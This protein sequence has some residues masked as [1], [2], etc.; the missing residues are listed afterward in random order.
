MEQIISLKD[1]PSV[2]FSNELKDRIQYSKL[3]GYV[4]GRPTES[5]INSWIRQFKSIMQEYLMKQNVEFLH[6]T[7]KRCF[8]I[9]YLTNDIREKILKLK[10]AEIFGY[11]FTWKEEIVN[12]I[13]DL[14]PRTPFKC[15]KISN[16]INFNKKILYDFC[17]DTKYIQDNISNIQN[18]VYCK[19]IFNDMST[20]KVK[21]TEIRA[22]D[23]R[24]GIF[25]IIDNECSTKNLDHIFPSI[26]CI[27]TAKHIQES[28]GEKDR[29]NRAGSRESGEILTAQSRT[30]NGEISHKEEAVT[31]PGENGENN[32]IGLVS[33]PILGILV[34]S[35]LYKYTPLR[36]KFHSYFGNKEDIPV[37]QD[38]VTTEQMISD[39]SNIGDMYSE[40]EHYNLS[41]QTL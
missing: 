36:L 35:F 34:F 22:L 32:A 26:D 39:T 18:S 21:L 17:E 19:S 4:T 10:G 7:D 20:R 41:Y 23:E 29:L 2:K 3:E 40:N 5:E 37:N 31:V 13:D 12:F 25:T 14:I 28:E 6:N 9:R 15:Q 38:Y 30:P 33:L 11:T 8:D 27:S 1:L 16:F 24:K